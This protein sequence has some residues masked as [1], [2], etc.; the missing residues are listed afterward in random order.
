MLVPVL[1]ILALIAAFTAVALHRAVIRRTERNL[2]TRTLSDV[3]AGECPPRPERVGGGWQVTVGEMI[4]GVDPAGGTRLGLFRLN[5]LPMPGG[6]IR[7]YLTAPDAV[8]Q[9][10]TDHPG[11]AYSRPRGLPA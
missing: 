7:R 8:P 6:D 2:A 9:F 3:L 5:L 10:L 11:A 4:V 1:T